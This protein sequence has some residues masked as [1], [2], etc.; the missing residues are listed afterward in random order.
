VHFS[1]LY[2]GHTHEDIDQGFGTIAGNLRK[3]DAETLP[4]LMQLLPNGTEITGGMFNVSSWL[5]PH[6]NVVTGQSQPLHYKFTQCNNSVKVYFKG[7]HNSPWITRELPLLS[8]AMPPGTPKQLQPD[9]SKI[10]IEKK[11][12]ALGIWRDLFSGEQSESSALW[13]DTWLKKLKNC[14]DNERSCTQYIKSLFGWILPRLPKQTPQQHIDDQPP[15]LPP[16]LQLRLD[17]ETAEPQVSINNST[18]M[19][20][21]G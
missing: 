16:S 10:N 4:D 14:R 13:W 21:C 17:A 12:K 8:R 18:C 3:H 5:A 20:Q 1:F 11:L 7:Q 9:F 15:S 6:I 2:V 19:G